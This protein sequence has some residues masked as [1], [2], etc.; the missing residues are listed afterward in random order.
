[1]DDA[2]LW[3]KQAEE[4]FQTARFNHDNEKYILQ[5]IKKQCL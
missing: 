3:L 2:G 5:W 4:D 1:M